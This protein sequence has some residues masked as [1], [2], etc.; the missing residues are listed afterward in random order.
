MY[1]VWYV[2]FTEYMCGFTGWYYGYYPGFYFHIFRELCGCDMRL[3]RHYLKNTCCFCHILTDLIGSKR[4]YYVWSCGPWCPMIS[5]IVRSIMTSRDSSCCKNTIVQLDGLP[6]S[7]GIYF[8]NVSKLRFREPSSTIVDIDGRTFYFDASDEAWIH[9]N[10][11]PCHSQIPVT[12]TKLWSPISF[13]P[14]TACKSPLYAAKFHTN[15]AQGSQV[16]RD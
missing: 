9:V 4:Q 8:S 16:H 12:V 11:L 15:T 2:D 5:R 3:N 1:R 10:A 7:C 6:P 14:P 13:H